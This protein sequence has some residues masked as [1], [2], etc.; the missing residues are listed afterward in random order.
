MAEHHAR[1]SLAA[2]GESIAFQA[3]DVPAQSRKQGIV[4]F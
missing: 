4:W 3:S 1:R 2:E